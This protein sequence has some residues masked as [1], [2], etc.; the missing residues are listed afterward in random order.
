MRGPEADMIVSGDNSRV[1][2]RAIIGNNPTNRYL[3]HNHLQ[4]MSQ[5]ARREGGLS[6][7]D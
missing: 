4:E 5:A 3:V 1:C 7:K 2:L 6:A